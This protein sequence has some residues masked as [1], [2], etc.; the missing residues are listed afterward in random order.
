[1]YTTTCVY[2][3]ACITQVQEHIH[4]LVVY[5]YG[6]MRTCVC[7]YTCACTYIYM[8]VFVCLYAINFTVSMRIDA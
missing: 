5:I 1:M 2:M 6:C 4:M 8:Y 3:Y 7:V